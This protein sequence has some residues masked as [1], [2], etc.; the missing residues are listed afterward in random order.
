VADVAE[1]NPTDGIWQLAG[2]GYIIET[3]DDQAVAT[4]LVAGDTCMPAQFLPIAAFNLAN[5]DE[6]LIEVD[7][8]IT[9]YAV[10]RISLP[11]VCSSFAFDASPQ[12]IMQ[13]FIALMDERY[14]FFEAR[15][16]DWPRAQV[17]LLASA[18][19]AT[20]TVE[21]ATIIGDFFWELGD[22]H[23]GIDGE[24]EPPA[25]VIEAFL[26][27]E[28]EL[29]LAAAEIEPALGETLTQDATG[30]LTWGTLDDGTG[31]LAIER[32]A[33]LDGINDDPVQD[34]VLMQQG[35][36]EALG[37]LAQA[38]GLIIDLRFNGG[39][40][41]GLSLE[42]ISRFIDEPTELFTK[43]AYAAP[44][45]TRQLVTATPSDRVK[46]EGDVAVLVSPA[47]ASA[48]EI[49]G[50]GM[51]EAGAQVVGPRSEGIFSDI[52][53]WLLPG[54][55]EM[56]MSMEVYRDLS[57]ESYEVRGVP[58]DVETSITDALTAAQAALG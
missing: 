16:M 45:A 39:G 34:L 8:S 43:E 53:P 37:D 18:Q 25:E 38:D 32:L 46:F 54:G 13:T 35:L 36:D 58:V 57:G 29:E 47:T 22:T 6:G 42:V 4:Y 7:A 55:L 1:E 49:L 14:P 3:E 28:A 50:V 19:A 52:I 17:R 40:T 30:V 31:Y 5:P 56:G 51:R 12:E 10:E 11:D 2:Y 44:D 15:E 9:N 41:D 48:A 27:V 21:I 24:S 26:Q 20:T 23:N 33:G